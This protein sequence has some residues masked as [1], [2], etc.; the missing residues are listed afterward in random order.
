MLRN[1]YLPFYYKILTIVDSPT[2]R[3]L[4]VKLMLSKKICH[5]NMSV[6]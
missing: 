2:K 1:F 5:Q 4:E 6:K 3:K